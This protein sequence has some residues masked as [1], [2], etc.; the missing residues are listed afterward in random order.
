MAHI[1]EQEL[2][3]KVN[4]MHPVDK[5]AKVRIWED[6]STDEKKKFYTM[7]CLRKL[8]RDA[9][10]LTVFMSDNACFCSGDISTPS[11]TNLWA[12][13]DNNDCYLNDVEDL[14][15]GDSMMTLVLKDNE[16]LSGMIDDANTSLDSLKDVI[17]KLSDVG[18]ESDGDGYRVIEKVL[19]TS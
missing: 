16:T 5:A 2:S 14:Q 8:I 9:D 1:T 3:D 18:E 4:N 19:E 6:M 17:I 15:D 11:T 10:E 7:I 12:H 13:P